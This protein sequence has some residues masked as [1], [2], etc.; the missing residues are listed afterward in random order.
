M[1]T[2]QYYLRVVCSCGM[3][4]TPTAHFIVVYVEIKIFYYM[5]E[6]VSQPE[7]SVRDVFSTDGVSLS[8]A[9]CYMMMS[10]HCCLNQSE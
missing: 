9:R 1:Q 6:A 2:A 3:M 8:R 5:G 4:H 10:A 7:G